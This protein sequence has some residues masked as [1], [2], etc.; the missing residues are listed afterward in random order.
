VAVLL[1]AAKKVAAAIHLWPAKKAKKSA[2][3]MSF[4]LN[5]LFECNAAIVFLHA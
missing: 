1:D 4:F 3:K 5:P 2:A